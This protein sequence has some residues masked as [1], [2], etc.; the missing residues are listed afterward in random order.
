[1]SSLLNMS[2]VVLFKV[3]GKQNLNGLSL[4]SAAGHVTRAKNHVCSVL[5]LFIAEMT[6]SPS[7]R[8]PFAI[9]GLPELLNHLYIDQTMA[10]YLYDKTQRFVGVTLSFR[11]QCN[12]LPTP[13]QVWW[14]TGCPS[15]GIFKRLFLALISFFFSQV[16]KAGPFAWCPLGHF[17]VQ[18]ASVEW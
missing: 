6:V 3:K 8:L 2:C 12:L 18:P 4:T 9:W 11:F 15:L 14:K 7:V 13:I 5:V 16:G 17:W 10:S 1:M